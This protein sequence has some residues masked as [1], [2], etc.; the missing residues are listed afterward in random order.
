MVADSRTPE[1]RLPPIVFLGPSLPWDEAAALLD[2]EFRPPIRRGD[3]AAVGPERLVVI[4]DGEFDQSFSVSLNEILRLLDA[5]GSVI[6]AASTA[7]LRS[8]NCRARE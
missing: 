1:C 7:A 4:I 8:P 2:A 5:G 6:G 3:M